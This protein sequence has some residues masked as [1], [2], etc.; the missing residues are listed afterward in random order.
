MEKLVNLLQDTQAIENGLELPD[1]APRYVALEQSTFGDAMWAYF[2]ESL[3]AIAQDLERSDT[4]FV[5]RIRVHDLDL[6]LIYVP[7]WKIDGFHEVPS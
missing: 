3:T 6:D 7:G 1:T 5:E 2:G 4:S